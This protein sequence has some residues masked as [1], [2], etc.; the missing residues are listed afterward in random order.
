MK[1]GVVQTGSSGL[2]SGRRAYDAFG[3]VVGSTG[4][5][6]GPFSYGGPFGY[7][8]DG[9]SGLLLLGHRYYDPTLGRFLSRDPI[10][11]GRNWYTYCAN[12][13]V[14]FADPEGTAAIM[15]AVVVIFFISMVALWA[16]LERADSEFWKQLDS[17][18]AETEDLEA[19][20]LE[21]MTDED[22]R[23]AY[24]P[25][26]SGG[27]NAVADLTKDAY[28]DYFVMAFVPQFFPKIGAI[29]DVISIHENMRKKLLTES[30][31]QRQKAEREAQRLSDQAPG[32]IPGSSPVGGGGMHYMPPF[33]WGGW[34][35]KAGEF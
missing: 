21:E 17:K 7:Q 30:E 11:D 3:N 5:W 16:F 10:K 8:T 26:R 1:S 27:V 28:T 20:P 32:V 4:T 31:R 29:L 34:Q 13:P 18:R 25:N 19:I 6:Q 12:N 23:G 35:G 14:R 33:R 24:H 2:V 22:L 15:V 9:D